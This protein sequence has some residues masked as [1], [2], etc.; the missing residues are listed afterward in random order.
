MRCR[1]CGAGCVLSGP[2]DLVVPDI[3]VTSRDGTLSVRQTLYFELA[4]GQ[5]VCA[6]CYL[7]GGTNLS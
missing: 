1:R 3:L 6:D 4:R 2:V 7:I 5:T